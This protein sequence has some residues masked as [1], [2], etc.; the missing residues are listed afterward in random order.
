MM[1]Q[2]DLIGD[3]KL[4]SMNRPMVEEFT[5]FNGGLAAIVKC[6]YIGKTL[7]WYETIPREDLDHDRGTRRDYTLHSN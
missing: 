1:I 6:S 5:P 2:S 7:Y 3:Y 4:T